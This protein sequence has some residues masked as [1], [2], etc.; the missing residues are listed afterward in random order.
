M[1]VP[2]LMTVASDRRQY[3][4]KSSWLNHHK[5]DFSLSLSL[6]ERA[7]HIQRKAFQVMSWASASIFFTVVYAYYSFFFLLFLSLFSYHH[8]VMNSQNCVLYLKKRALFRESRGKYHSYISGQQQRL[9]KFQLN[10]R[11]STRAN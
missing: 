5:I 11:R 6:S 1:D 4:I 10:P 3:L 8:L 7:V 9:S 2:W